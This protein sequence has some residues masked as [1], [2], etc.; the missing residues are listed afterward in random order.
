MMHCKSLSWRWIWISWRWNFF[1]KNKVTGSAFRGRYFL[2]F[3]SHW[4]RLTDTDVSMTSR[5]ATVPHLY[6]LWNFILVRKK[7]R[8]L[9]ADSCE[10]W[11]LTLR[12]TRCHTFVVTHEQ[13][14]THWQSAEI[15]QIMRSAGDRLMLLNFFCKH[16]VWHVNK[17]RN[18]KILRRK[19]LAYFHYWLTHSSY[20]F[21]HDQL[22]PMSATTLIF[23]FPSEKSMYLFIGTVLLK[24]R[25]QLLLQQGGWEDNYWVNYVLQLKKK[26]KI[27]E[28][29]TSIAIVVCL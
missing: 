24:M 2:R 29:Q 12:R 21:K 4:S 3:A 25:I 6:V 19:S 8:V 15:S 9:P 10:H 22:W 7:K 27:P 1:S 26:K 17:L 11:S 20:V 23:R 13:T 5:D 28:S 14:L 18:D 16:P